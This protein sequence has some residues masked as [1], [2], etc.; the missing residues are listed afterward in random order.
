VDL[1]S[2]GAARVVPIAETGS[3]PVSP[4]NHAAVVADDY[5]LAYRLYLYTSPKAAAGFAQR[6]VEYAVSPAGQA[7]VEQHGLISPVLTKKVEAAPP[8]TEAEKLRAF[9]KGAKRLAI[10]FR[11]Q[12]NSTVLDA[13]GERDLDRVTNYL[14]SLHDG[15]DHLLLAGFADNQGDAA[16]NIE[17][18]KKR[19]D[20]VAALFLRRGLTPG[21]VA[22]FGAELPVA[23]N[24]TEAGRE[25]NRR[26]EVY[27]KP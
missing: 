19:A 14:V 16:T 4:L 25:R 23:D 12:A 22:G 10:V 1:A 2:A 26:V 5:P 24:G 21:G 9:V 17:V 13:F 15:G 7:I 27:I 8:Q 18:S 6:F 3:T 20:A 11:F